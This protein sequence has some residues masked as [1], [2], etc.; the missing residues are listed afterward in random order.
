MHLELC[1]RFVGLYL[2]FLGLAVS[3]SLSYWI[4]LELKSLKGRIEASWGSLD[5]TEHLKW[6][7]VECSRTYGGISVFRLSFVRI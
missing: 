3:W 4:Q 2:V 6:T 1:G 7:Q 5:I